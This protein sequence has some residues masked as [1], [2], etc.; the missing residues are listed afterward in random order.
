[1]LVGTNASTTWSNTTRT[2]RLCCRS[3]D[4]ILERRRWQRCCRHQKTA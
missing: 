1:L 2:W 3:V 4:G